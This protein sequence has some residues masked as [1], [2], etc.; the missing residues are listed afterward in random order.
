MGFSDSSVGKESPCSARD[1][2]WQ[3]SLEKEM[4]THPSILTWKISWTEE[5]VGLQSMGLVAVHRLLLIVVASFRARALGPKLN[6]CARVLL[7]HWLWDP[8]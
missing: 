2:G 1:L 5:P 4:A 6:R 3:D 8:P 7:L